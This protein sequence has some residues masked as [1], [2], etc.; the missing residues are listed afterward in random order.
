M[1]INKHDFKE[2]S[3]LVAELLV[4]RASGH[5]FD[6]QRE[7]P[8]W[9]IENS[10]LKRLIQDGLGGVI[11]LGGNTLELQKRTEILRNWTGNNILICA[12]VEEGIGQRFPG[13]SDLVPPI[14]LGILYQNRP[15]EAI[16]LA[17]EYGRCIGREARKIGL[18][19]V[20]APVADIN[21]NKYNPVIN[22][23]SWGETNTVVSDLTCAFNSGL[24]SEGILS[25]AK[26]FPGHGDTSI[27]SHLELPILNYSLEELKKR[28][29][30]PFIRLIESGVDSIMSGHVLLPKIDSNYPATL[31]SIFLN[32]LLRKDLKYNG[33]VVTDALI[34]KAIS[35]KY[36]S[37]E[38]ALMAFKAGADLIMMPGKP[39]EAISTISNEIYSG[40]I[41]ISRLYHSLERRKVALQKINNYKKNFPAKETNCSLEI[42]DSQ[43]INFSHSLISKTIEVRNPQAYIEINGTNIIQ[44]DELFKSTYLAKGSPA[45]LLPQNIGCETVLLHSL[46]VSPWTNKSSTPLYLDR[47]RKGSFLIQ[48]FSRGNPFKGELITHKLWYNVLRQL[49]KRNLLSGLVVYGSHYLW[50]DLVKALPDNMPCA[51]TP[52]DMLEA[53]RQVL[54]TLFPNCISSKQHL[55]QKV[56][57]FTS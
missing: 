12:D 45:I 56:D 20:L 8:E 19:W 40:K 7:Y 47:I 48:I 52:G 24:C 32:N 2:I 23:R 50:N 33:L 17:E 25:C 9:E 6:S 49:L 29:L 34:M 57:V 1:T 53:Q 44:I 5:L 51:Y 39:Y 35:Y 4:I 55:K 21:T 10:K 3:R 31:S 22:I 14:A 36:G 54:T 41:P 37:G 28:E 15:E 26:H 27:D 16:L 43:S 11:L 38:A 46:G 30:I 18:N 13:G 42:I